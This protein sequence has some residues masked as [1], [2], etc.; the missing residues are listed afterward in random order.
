MTNRYIMKTTKISRTIWLIIILQCICVSLLCLTGCKRDALKPVNPP[1]GVWMWSSAISDS[2]SKRVVDQLAENNIR[3]VYFLVKGTAGIKTSPHKLR[4]FISCAREKEMEVHLWYI[5]S[6]DSTYI[7]ENP[8]ASIYHC[9]NPSV[10][11]RPYPMNDQ[12]VNLLY[13]GY[14][15]YVLDNIRDF[16]NNFDCDGVHLDYI[17]F[18]HFVYSFDPYSLQKAAS[19]GCDTT[20]LLNLFTT[21]PGYTAH[22]TNNGFVE[23]YAE[24]DND[25][26]TWV[27]MRKNIIRDYI[28]SIGE[29]VRKTKPGLEV[30]AAFMPEGT[31][32]TIYSDVYYAQNYMLHSPALDRISPMA[33]FKS[34]KKPTSWLQTVTEGAKKLCAPQCEVYTGIQA[35]NEVT[36]EELQEQIKYSLE[37]GAQG[38]ILFRYGG[39]AEEG[40]EAIRE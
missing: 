29:V 8:Q 1:R 10:S 33:Y 7:A 24:G 30:S 31:I 18:S 9:P 3:Q 5:V 28:E 4:T 34:Y 13:P 35:F 19:L 17:R 14:K 39:I 21:E 6:E 23:L 37:G 11:T 26:V 25:V 36:N 22:A 12:R 32:D 16:L 2:N 27:G 20:R 38:V 40:W 15:D